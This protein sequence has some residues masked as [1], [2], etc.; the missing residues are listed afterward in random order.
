MSAEEQDYERLGKALFLAIND[1]LKS[2]EVE[3]IFD[4]SDNFRQKWT[5]IARRAYNDFN[6]PS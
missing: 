1:D 3:G 2:W 6:A 4:G 5:D